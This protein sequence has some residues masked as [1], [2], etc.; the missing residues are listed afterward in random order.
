MGMGW[1]H[2]FLKKDVWLGHP[3]G[4]IVEVIHQQLDNCLFR[5]LQITHRHFC[6]TEQATLAAFNPEK[7]GIRFKLV[8]ID[9]FLCWPMIA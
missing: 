4:D 2:F 1:A 6:P 5:A 9:T 3:I 8:A 7:N